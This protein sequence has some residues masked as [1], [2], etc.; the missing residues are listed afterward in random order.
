VCAGPIRGY[1]DSVTVSKFRPDVI[2][3]FLEA[4]A[5][6]CSQTTCAYLAGVDPAQ[7]SRWLAKGKED[8]EKGLDTAKARFYQ[9]YHKNQATTNM[10]ALGIIH[11]EMETNPTLAWKY[12]ERREPGYAPP[13]P[14]LPDRREGPVVIQL[15]LSNGQPAAAL[16]PTTVI[17]VEGVNNGDSGADTAPEPATPAPT[18]V[19]LADRSSE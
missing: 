5:V 17:D 4:A 14:A 13:A 3:T 7:G 11:R 12:V 10:R 1:R 6:G 2:E 9:A 15:T 16:Q 8:T 18:V 19:T